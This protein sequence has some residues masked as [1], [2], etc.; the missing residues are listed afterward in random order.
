MHQPG[1][2]RRGLRVALC[3][4]VAACVGVPVLASPLEPAGRGAAGPLAAPFRV[5]RH[6]SPEPSAPR[7]PG[8]QPRPATNPGSF[9]R[10][11][12]KR[13]LDRLTRGRNMG[14][15]VRFDGEA[16]YGHRDGRLRRPAS[17][18][19]LL[20][21]MALLDSLGPHAR[22]STTAA[23]RRVQ[24]GVVKGDL[25]ILGRGDPTVAGGRRYGRRL[26]LRP[27]TL[28]RIAR[29]I[30]AAGIERIRGRIMGSKGYF[31]HDWSAPG[32][33]PYYR[34]LY[35]ALPSALSFNGNVAGGRFIR[36]PE[37]RLAEALTH[38][39]QDAGIAV[40]GRPGAG[41]P[42]R[43]LDA[44]ARVRS[45]PLSKLLRYTNRTSSN[46]FAEVL[47]KRLGAE[48]LGPAGTIAKGARVLRRWARGRGI[49]I[50]A[51]DSSGLSHANRIS[52]RGLSRL[53]SRSSNAPWGGVLRRSLAAPGQGTLEDRLRGVRLRAKTGTLIGV[54]ALSG[55]VWLERRDGWAEFS[56]LSSGLAKSRAVSVED[57]IV[58]LLAKRAA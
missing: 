7:R 17:N 43:R 4:A 34:S 40:S 51:H 16:I 35:I 19:K 31:A 42:P 11:G 22:V 41:R 54:S 2:P 47:G 13:K 25:W 58:R 5:P 30:A 12:W 1:A 9:S 36:D 29:R 45:A 49:K 3:V 23:A 8:A 24:S 56:I 28:G 55:W 38:R 44:L 52:A 20:L 32:W 37:R 46:F 15:A 33:R 48:R 27:T 57:A 26:G 6:P 10:P 18:E 21:S 14:V 39:L 50:A 53:L